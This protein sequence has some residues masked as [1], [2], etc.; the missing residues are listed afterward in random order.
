M[1]YLAIIIFTLLSIIWYYVSWEYLKNI[2]TEIN[3]YNKNIITA[4]LLAGQL[5][6]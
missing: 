6:L 5:I 3:Q 1:K 2:N 4:I